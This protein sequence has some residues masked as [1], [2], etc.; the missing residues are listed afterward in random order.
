MIELKQ[1][2]AAAIL[3]AL[4][5]ASD[6]HGFDTDSLVSLLEYPP[7]DTMGDLAMPCFRFAK[8]LHRS[9]AMI[10]EQF[11]KELSIPG[12]RTMQAVNGY[13]N[14]TIDADYMASAL[15]AKIRAVGDRYGSPECGQAL[16]HR[17]SRNDGNRPFAEASSRICRISLRRYQPSWR[18]GNPV[19]QID[20]CLSP[21]GQQ[22]SR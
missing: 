18:L 20:C 6:S 10:A 9:P 22:R 14:F 4:H 17:T 15:L 2:I 11:A 8:A 3:N 16:S 7:D 5:A 1:R 19:R 13:L 12:I 21:V